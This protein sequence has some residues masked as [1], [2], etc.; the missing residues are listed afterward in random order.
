VLTAVPLTLFTA[1]AKRLNL[2]TVGLL[3]YIAPTFM[4]L[5][6]VFYYREPF[7]TAQVWTFIMI[8]TALIIYS[9]DSVIYF[10]KYR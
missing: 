5:L 2:S 9:T 7:A 10:R 3:Q 4:F 8:W 6:A 1:G